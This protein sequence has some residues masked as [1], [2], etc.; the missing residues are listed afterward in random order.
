MP[1]T[2]DHLRVLPD[3]NRPN[4][5]SEGGRRVSFFAGKTSR[6][7]SEV[8]RGKVV[9][10]NSMNTDSTIEEKDLRNGQMLMLL[11]M[12][13]GYHL[14]RVSNEDYVRY[15]EHFEVISRTKDIK[16]GQSAKEALKSVVTIQVF[17]SN[18]YSTAKKR[19]DE[20]LEEVRLAA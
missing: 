11:P 4:G 5:P 14:C 13:G 16:L 19:F 2:P 17:G 1:E 10:I 9:S 3:E 18:D 12:N 7:V 6:R 20:V 8:L 15:R